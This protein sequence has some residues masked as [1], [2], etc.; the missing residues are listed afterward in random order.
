MKNLP[1]I[2]LL[3]TALPSTAKT[4]VSDPVQPQVTHCRFF[5]LP[6]SPITAPVAKNLSGQ[7]YCWLDVT[8][9]PFGSYTVRATAAIMNVD[10]SIKAQS[11]LSNPTT[12]KSSPLAPVNLT[13]TP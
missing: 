3:S 8:D 5:G 4:I 2:L 11:V 13:V 7:P 12:F 10:G 6:G 1:L 9:T